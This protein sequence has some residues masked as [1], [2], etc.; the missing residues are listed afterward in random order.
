[1][2]FYFSGTGNTEYVAKVMAEKLG[3]R[4]VSIA[5]AI[6]DG[7]TVFTLNDGESLGMAFPTYS[8]GPAPIVLQFLKSLKI[9][10][11]VKGATYCY[12]VTTCGD[13]IGKSVDIWRK[14]L[15]DGI[16]GDAAFSVQ[17]PNNYIVLPG[18][19]VDPK[20]LERK[21]IE[22][23]AE[24]IEYVVK[25]IAERR[26]IVDVVT[27][28]WKGLKSG[29][30]RAWFLKYAMSDKPFHVDT[31]LCTSCG[32]CVKHCP[33][34]NVIF[35]SENHPTWNGNCAMCL[36]CIHRC[37]ARAIQYGNRTQKKGR[38]HFK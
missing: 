36:S 14:A 3:E 8:W 10:G 22:M 31:E 28:N 29:L 1:M 6:V 24:R 13:D 17:M 23:S 4:L 16:N 19:D 9:N 5:D 30:I 27:G 38:Y 12:M 33:T 18:F 7:K 11:Y 32:V 15:P 37:P 26:H 35:D 2:I 20:E 21:K 25:C 34:K